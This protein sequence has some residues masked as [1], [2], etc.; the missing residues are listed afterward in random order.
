MFKQGGL[1]KILHRTSLV[2]VKA[3]HVWLK[4]KNHSESHVLLE[5]KNHTM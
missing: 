4:E 5:R 2:Q 3:I 1:S